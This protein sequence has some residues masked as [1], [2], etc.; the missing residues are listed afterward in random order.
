MPGN[1]EWVASQKL[2]LSYDF[3]S[4]LW[5]LVCLARQAYRLLHKTYTFLEQ[6]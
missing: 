2:S 4:N 3:I 1:L 6:D 5:K